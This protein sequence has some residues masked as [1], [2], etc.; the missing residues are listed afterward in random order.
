M[1]DGGQEL[2]PDL[3]TKA[4]S[5]CYSLVMN[6]PFIDGNKR[7]AFACCDVFL[8]LNGLEIAASEVNVVRTMLDL[9]AGTLDNA[10]LVTWITDHVSTLPADV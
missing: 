2:Y 7:T 4:A 8:Q 10:Q 6:H 1:A 5:L 9:A 3:P